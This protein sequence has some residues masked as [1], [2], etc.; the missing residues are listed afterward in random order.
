M[1]DYEFER[2][3]ASSSGP[4][5][6]AEVSRSSENAAKNRYV[7]VI[8]FDRN[9]V[10]LSA[11]ALGDYINAS[12]ITGDPEESHTMAAAQF[13]AIGSPR[14]ISSADSQTSSHSV[15]SSSQ[16]GQSSS[17]QSSVPGFTTP[18]HRPTS[19]PHLPPA[20]PPQ[21][22]VHRDPGPPAHHHRRLLAD[23]A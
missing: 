14:K 5:A 2:L 4:E 22:G 11:G 13:G 6:P 19:P 9:R 16:P 7:N 17:Q 15:G 20:H 3:W 10:C 23:G 1:I 8:P 18:T 12:L 21:P